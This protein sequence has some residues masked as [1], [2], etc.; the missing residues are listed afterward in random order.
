ML[1]PEIIQKLTLSTRRMIPIQ[2][3]L[4][5]TSH[6]HGMLLRVLV[7][8]IGRTGFLGQDGE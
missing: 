7:A 2:I 3:F 4:H 6:F 1:Q 5:S 8:N